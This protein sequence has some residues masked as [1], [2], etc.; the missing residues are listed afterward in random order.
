MSLV[1]MYLGAMLPVFVRGGCWRGARGAFNK[2]K[3]AEL[4]G[5]NNYY[6]IPVQ[7]PEPLRVS[8]ARRCAYPSFCLYI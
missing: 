6:L 2:K 8:G 7:A 4:L 3:G 1:K 5:Q